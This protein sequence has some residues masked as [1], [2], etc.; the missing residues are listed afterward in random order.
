M[1]TMNRYNVIIAFFSIIIMTAGCSKNLTENGDDAF[2]SKNYTEALKYYLQAAK[3]NPDDSVLYEKIALAYFR[4]GEQ[5][6]EKRHVIKAFEARMKSGLQYLPVNPTREMLKEVSNTYLKLA[7]AYKEA[8]AE[9]PFEE[10]KFLNNALGNIEKS[11]AI[12]STNNEARQALQSF[13]E[14]YFMGILEKG[15]TCYKKGTFDPLQYIA[16]DYYLTNAVKLD[17]DNPEAL[18]Y[19]SMA[20]KKGL[21]LLDP[22]LDVPIA[23][24]DRMQNSEYTAFLVV[25]YN[26]L[27]GNLYVSADHFVL[28]K[29][30]GQE[31]R[32]RTS[33][34]F[35]T[36]LKGQTLQNGDETQGVVAF[37]VSENRNDAR[38][39]FRKD[40]EVLGYKN[41]P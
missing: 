11:L 16:A 15:L 7:Y 4:E 36:P 29:E 32:G 35:T 33:G 8:R 34:M 5:F 37:P 14:E 30:N 38:L 21:N 31:V 39:E 2:A 10:R 41:L 19:R 20:R 23:I 18:K 9:N 26:L 22:G 1:N 3:E 6:Y 27:P 25:I 17:P 28:I 40:G 13:K 24:T 12:D